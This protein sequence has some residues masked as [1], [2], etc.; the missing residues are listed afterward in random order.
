MMM[1]KK[2]NQYNLYKPNPMDHQIKRR[3]NSNR[4]KKKTMNKNNKSYNNKNKRWK[5]FIKNLSTNKAKKS[6]QN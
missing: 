2:Q 3:R 1:K 5:I 4:K 6:N